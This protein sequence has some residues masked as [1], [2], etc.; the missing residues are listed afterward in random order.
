MHHNTL[1]TVSMWSLECLD[2]YPSGVM[3]YSHYMYLRKEVDLERIM[4]REDARSQHCLT[5]S[6]SLYV[7][8]NVI[9]VDMEIYLCVLL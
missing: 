9:R 2:R 8:N 5:L 7:H 4:S 6:T 3:D 1:L